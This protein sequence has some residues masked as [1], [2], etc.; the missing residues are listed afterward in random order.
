[1]RMIRVQRSLL[2]VLLFGVAALSGCG[3]FKTRSPVNVGG[4]VPC[5]TPNSPDDV[6]ANLVARYGELQGI[7]CYSEMLDSRFLFHPDPQ[8]SIQELPDTVYA[9]WTRDVET[10]VAG[11]LAAEATFHLAVLDSEYANRV[12]S[13][14]NRTETRFYAYHLILHATSV[15]PDTLF[16]GLADITFVQGNNAQ[17]HITNW[18]DKRDLSGARTWGYVRARYRSSG[19]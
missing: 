1:M 12:V 8:D 16:R 14:D 17:W 7:T 13:S 4:G 10:V 2:A 11:K 19:S 5:A 18:Q 9:N 15:A 6:V 3:L